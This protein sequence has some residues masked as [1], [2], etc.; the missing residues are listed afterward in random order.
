MT[1]LDEALRLAGL[2][3]PVFPLLPKSK[4]PATKTGFKA[5]TTSSEMIRAWWSKGEFNIG[6]AIP[7]GVM[8]LDIDGMAYEDL[9]HDGLYIPVE[10]PVSNTPGKGGGSHIWVQ[11]PDGTQ[12]SPKVN[13]IPGIDIRSHG[14]YVVVPPSFHPDGG[15]Y[16]WKNRLE[17]LRFQLPMAPEW[18]VNLLSMP[19]FPSHR[20]TLDVEGILS[21]I[22]PGKRQITLWRYAC[23]LR[24]LDYHK[25]EAK[26][27]VHAVAEN[28]GS[29]EYDTDRMVDRAWKRYDANVNAR[30]TKKIWKLD[31]LMKADLGDPEW[32]VEDL[33]HPGT[34][35]VYSDPKSG[36]SALLA[37]LLL[38]IATGQK[39]WGRYH[40]P[41]ARGVLYLDLEQS[42]IPGKKRW[43]KIL[44]GR[45]PPE[46]LNVAFDWEDKDKGGVEELRKYLA[47]HSDVDVVVVDVLSVF[48][49]PKEGNVYYTEYALLQE[50]RKLQK[51]FGITLFMVHHTNKQGDVSGS[52]AMKGS[53]DILI[54]LM[55]DDGATNATAMIKGKNVAQGEIYFTVDL[56]KMK[57]TAIG[58]NFNG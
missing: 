37:N 16:S 10:C 57:W 24:A 53:P 41:K 49:Q 48:C 32:V 11:L 50:L 8:V 38:A 39:A 55:R 44:D 51:E 29:A 26:I 54:Q 22:E 31:E 47:M 35:L 15:Q 33:I 30:D 13:V 45:E 34:V 36:K 28:S 18:A 4:A 21:G 20:E 3:W 5:A 9:A 46:N 14:S 27:L 17:S 7:E 1:N 25:A 23:R 43:R 19:N 42:D 2:G 6:V 56:S 58:D 12:A 40:I 52:M